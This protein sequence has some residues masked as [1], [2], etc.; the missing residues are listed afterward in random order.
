[1]AEI[2]TQENDASVTAFIDAVAH[3]RRQQEAASVIAMMERLTGKP[4][5]MWGKSIVGF[6][7]Y[8]YKY[9]SGQSGRWPI[10]GLSP[11][12]ANLSL[13]IMP[14]FE[15]F[16]AELAMLGPHKTGSSCLYLTDLRKIDMDVLE[17]IVARSIELMRAKHTKPS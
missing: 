3:T 1:M 16:C 12:K 17:Q 15:P 13:Y 10:V 8:D 4:P 14:G 2:K 5:R 11:R 7:A 6:D 9:D